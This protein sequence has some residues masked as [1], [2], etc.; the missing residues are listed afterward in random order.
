LITINDG[1]GNPTGYEGG[2]GTISYDANGN[3]LT[4]PDRTIE[5]IDYNHLNLPTKLKIEG[6]N[7]NVAYRYRADG[8]KLKKSFIFTGDDGA[9]YSSSTEYLDGFHYVSSTG[10]E[11]W[12]AFY[13][14]AASA[15]EPEAFVNMVSNTNFDNVLKFFPTAEGF[16]D[17]ENN[18]YIYQY[19]DHLGNVRLSF[20]REGNQPIVTN[21]NDFYPFGMSFVRN[22]EEDAHFGT[23]SYFNY[24]YNGKELQ[25]TG[26]YDYGARFYMPD[27]GRW[28]V[29][30]PLAET[31]RRWS[32]YTYAYNNPIRFIDPDGRQ[33]EDIILQGLQSAINKARD[34]MNEG[35]G[36]NYITVARDGQVKIDISNEQIAGLDKTQKE[37]YNV[38]NSAI[39]SDNKNTFNLSE[40]DSSVPVA[41]RN[42]DTKIVN[43]DI[44][45]VNN[46]GSNTTQFNR[47]TVLGHEVAEQDALLSGGHDDYTNTKGTGHHDIGKEAESKIN[48][49]W[50][51]GDSIFEGQTVVRES[52]TENGFK[53]TFPVISRTVTM[54]FTKGK[55]VI[56]VSYELQKGNVIKKK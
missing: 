1:S 18:E 33:N 5:K 49:G 29:V 15:Y 9:L 53:R 46:L 38:L 12:W 21:S 56:H 4:M 23:G 55:S 51:R 45:D 24:K 20:K 7:K 14:E 32:P 30:D 34:L 35:L 48:G 22:S 26:M 2:G 10:D 50:K 41:N 42:P 13:E 40:S 8:T 19:K 17:F 6:Y 39:E 25:E 11:L 37:F 16:Y 3:M 44:D 52:R 43:L 47:F 31:S 36:G 27:I 28:G 54:P